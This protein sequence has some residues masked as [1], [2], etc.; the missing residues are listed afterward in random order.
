MS[1]IHFLEQNLQHSPTVPSKTPKHPTTA[2]F[3]NH[4]INV[5]GQL[6]EEDLQRIDLQHP[7]AEAED[8]QLYRVEGAEDSLQEIRQSLLLCRN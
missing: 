8:V 2:S 6:Q 4:N 3:T 1:P 5:S 7:C